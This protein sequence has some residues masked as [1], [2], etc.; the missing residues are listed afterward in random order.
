MRYRLTIFTG[1]CAWVLIVTGAFVKNSE[2]ASGQAQAQ[3]SASIFNVQTHL[4]LAI[5]V[6]AL[7]IALVLWNRSALAFASL[8]IL[9]ADAATAWHSAPLPAGLGILHALLAPLF[10]GS[11]AALAFFDSPAHQRAPAMVDGGKWPSLGSLA[12]ATTV[13]IL[14]QIVLGAG[15]RH[16]VLTV[17]PHMAIAL[18]V[19]LV[20]LV[21]SVVT[22]QLFPSHKSLRG[23]A[24]ALIS[25]MIL[26]VAL[27]IT[28]FALPLADQE[29]GI[30]YALTTAGHVSTGALALVASVNLALRVRRY[31]RTS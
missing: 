24:T 15:Y 19:I 22:L 29:N 26:Q 7:M 16:E 12:D 1:L 6:A 9:A 4:G 25:I 8:A 17:I 13:A 3:W 28:A 2:R 18:A 20:S 30:L 27:G 23:G 5:F 21:V 11:I 10:L 31:V 14:A